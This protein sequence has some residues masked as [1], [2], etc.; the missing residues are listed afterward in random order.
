MGEKIVERQRQKGVESPQR[1]CLLN[2]NP[3]N[4]VERSPSLSRDPRIVDRLLDN[5]VTTLLLTLMES[6]SRIRTAFVTTHM[7]V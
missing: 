6:E 2:R 1:E 3:D 7:I 5:G 4:Q